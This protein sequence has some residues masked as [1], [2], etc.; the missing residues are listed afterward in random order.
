MSNRFSFSL[1]LFGG[2]KG[3]GSQTTNNNYRPL[4][5]DELR[6]QKASADYAEAIQPSAYNLFQ[7]S[8]GMLGQP[9]TDTTVNP[10]Y[11]SLY[12]KQASSTAANTQAQNNISNGLLPQSFIDN[13]NAQA[14]SYAKSSMGN[15]LSNMNSRG[16]VNSSVMGSG[17][18]SINKNLAETFQNS[19]TNDLNTASGLVSKNQEYANMPI[20]QA[21]QAQS[22]SY[23][24]PLQLFGAA[25]GQMQ[26]TQQ[27]WQPTLLSNQSNPTSSTTTTSG[28]GG[29]LFGGI[30]GGLA[31]N[32]GIFGR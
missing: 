20:Q 14:Q 2:G 30:L 8:M 15:L 22:A 4:T 19:Y 25:T 10:N 12:N 3:G 32:P 23:Q 13:R 17:M 16:V 1:Q 29:G 9:G 21:N 18:D 26:P 24:M 31:G 7:R 5:S 27:I 6:M 28:G 11:N